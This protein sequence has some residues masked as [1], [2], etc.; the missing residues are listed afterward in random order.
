MLTLRT[1]RADSCYS[2]RALTLSF[3]GVDSSSIKVLHLILTQLIS[4]IHRV[5]DKCFIDGRNALF[6]SRILLLIFPSGTTG[7]HLSSR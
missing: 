4:P 2:C 5:T 1:A 6:Y 3:I 7:S